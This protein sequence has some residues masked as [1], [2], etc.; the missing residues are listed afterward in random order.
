MQ[1]MRSMEKREFV[2]GIFDFLSH[3]HGC[4]LM[5]YE[6]ALCVA[7]SKMLGLEGTLKVILFSGV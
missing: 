3:K 1:I 7:C 4:L 5:L 2:I 6:Q